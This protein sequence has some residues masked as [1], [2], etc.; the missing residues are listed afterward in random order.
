MKTPKCL[1]AFDLPKHRLYLDRSTLTEY[2]SVLREQAGMG[3]FAQSPKFLV[4]LDSTVTL[5]SRASIT[6]GTALT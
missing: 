6:L 4:S 2:L 1:I 5:R 3:R